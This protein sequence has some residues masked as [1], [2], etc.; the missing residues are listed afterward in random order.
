MNRSD[1]LCLQRMIEKRLYKRWNLYSEQIFPLYNSWSRL[2]REILFQHAAF[3]IWR[4]SLKTPSYLISESRFYFKCKN[5]SRCTV[6][7]FAIEGILIMR[8]DKCGVKNVSLIFI[9][10]N[11]YECNE[12]INISIICCTIVFL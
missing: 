1:F 12:F 3:S 5:D 8:T 10:K 2:F 9:N 4:D 6:E 11:F 7:I